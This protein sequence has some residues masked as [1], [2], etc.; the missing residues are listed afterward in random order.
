MIEIMYRL[1]KN[2][3][4][5]VVLPDG[6]MF[7]TDNSKS[8]IKKK[9][10]NEFN[11]HTVIRLPGSCFAPYTS[12]A[13]NLL[14]FD[15]TTP[16]ENVWFYRMDLVNGQKFS[17]TKNPMTREKFACMDEWWDNRVE[18]K[19]EKIDES[20]TETWKSRLVNVKEIVDSDYSL[21][22]CGYPVKEK[23]ILS[24]EETIK[25]FQMERDRLDKEMDKK[26][27]EILSLLGIEKED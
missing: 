9:L 7:G 2:G 1:K 15:N 22:F 20:M 18:I 17:L 6:F 13:T 4:C 3:R 14:F 16:T 8:A 19:D 11:L 5:G 25:N 26:L 24:P 27:A 10:L 21:D 23:V 12:I